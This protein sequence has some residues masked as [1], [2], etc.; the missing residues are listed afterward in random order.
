MPSQHRATHGATHTCAPVR[1]VR[2][3]ESARCARRSGASR[4]GVACAIDCG[5][6]VGQR[7]GADVPVS[8]FL[9]L[10][11]FVGAARR[12]RVGT[13]GRLL[14]RP[15]PLVQRYTGAASPTIA[16]AGGGG[17]MIDVNASP[18][19]R[20]ILMSAD[21]VGGVWQYS[22]LLGS[23]LRRRGI[24]VGIATMGKLPTV[25]QRTEAERA[26][27]SL[28]ISS[29]KLE[30][31]DDAWCDVERAGD[32]LLQVADDFRPDLVHLNG[33]LHSTLPWRQPHLVVGHSCVCS[34]WEAVH[35]TPLP[36]NME[37]YREGVR[38]GL[39]AARRIIAP[40]Q[41]MLAALERHYG[42][43]HTSHIIYNAR[44]PALYHSMI[45][46][47]FVLSVGRAWDAGMNLDTVAAAAS[48]IDW[49]VYIA[50]AMRHPQGGERVMK[51]V[52][53]LGP[54][55]ATELARWYASASL[56]VAPAR[57][58]P[59][60]LS[61][62]EAAPSGCALILGDIPSQRELWDG[63]AV[64]VDPHDAGA[65]AATVN[66]LIDDEPQRLRFMASARQ[67]AGVVRIDGP[68]RAI[69]QLALTRD[70]AQDQR[71][72]RERGRQDRRP[73]RLVA[74]GGH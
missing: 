18:L 62:L 47:P 59:F 12:C 31:M 60:G 15:F 69:P 45:K 29:Y 61:V 68:R 8:R 70:I 41:A 2:A 56:F 17:P 32:W 72:P 67:R 3:G 28:F 57:Y 64:F 43:L 39:Q 4:R 58:E 54:H 10:R 48:A 11:A 66:A 71:A 5:G 42:P 34:W 52:C 36:A 6:R 14:P 26:G 55:G 22:V 73:E 1:A 53:A 23:E 33:Y 27:L 7:A 19:P 9:C 20:R 74:R 63:A 46:Q 65:L 16:G 30:W 37:R 38:A 21:T 44:R 24:D 49:P 50:G 35:G 25:G 51:D 40:S 13:R